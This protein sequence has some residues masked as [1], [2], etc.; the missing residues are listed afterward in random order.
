MTAPEEIKCERCGKTI[1]QTKAGEWRHLP[2]CGNARFHRAKPAQ[3]AKL[4]EGDIREQLAGIIWEARGMSQTGTAYPN[5]RDY[6]YADQITPLINAQVEE[7]RHDIKLVTEGSKLLLDH[8]VCKAVEEEREKIRQGLEGISAV[9][10]PY[11]D[12]YNRGI[13]EDKWQAFW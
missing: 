10:N 12:K 13:W 5:S 3:L 8:E 2:Y 11:K 7:A 6:E 1:T 4:C 9:S